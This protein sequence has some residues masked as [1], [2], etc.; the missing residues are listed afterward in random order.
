MEAVMVEVE[1]S[2]KGGEVGKKDGRMKYGIQYATGV[3][4]SRN[5]HC[6]AFMTALGPR[7][8]VPRQRHPLKAGVMKCGL[9]SAVN[10]RGP[11]SLH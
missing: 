3:L 10:G 11:R 5:V 9:R 1:G 6:D 4:V 2:G 7:P 8:N